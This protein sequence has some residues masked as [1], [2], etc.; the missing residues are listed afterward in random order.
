MKST[1]RRMTK[2]QAQLMK[3]HQLMIQLGNYPQVL[4]EV[5]TLSQVLSGRSIAR[6]GDGELSL[7]LGGTCISQRERPQ[8]L[9]DELKAILA[10]DMNHCLVGIP[11]VF[12]QT[13]KFLNWVKFAQPRYTKLFK[14][15]IYGSAFITRPDSAPWIDKPDY[16]DQCRKLWRNRDV[17]LVLGTERSL[18]PA[19][20]RAEGANVREVW[21]PRVDAY[22]YI[23]VL[24]EE[25]GKPSHPV[26]LCLGPTATVLAWRLAQKGV[27]AIDLGHLGMTMRKAERGGYGNPA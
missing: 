20:M 5:E 23:N 19:D 25:I 10:G 27:W 21:G 24:M 3:K 8:E 9:Q 2:D 17:T 26:L 4:S 11:N 18:R 13:P 15:P 1:F 22:K 12:S 7:A 6:Y 14:R 16:W